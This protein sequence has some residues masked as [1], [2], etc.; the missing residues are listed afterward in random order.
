MHKDSI[1]IRL[2]LPGLSDDAETAVVL[3]VKEWQDSIEVVARYSNGEAICPRCGHSTWQVHQWRQQRKRDAKVWGKAMWLLLWK[4]RFRCRVCR[5]VFTEPDPACGRYRR[6][7]RRLR[8]EVAQQ[9][10]EASV[11][12]V[13]P[14]TAAVARWQEVSEGL[15]QRSWRENHPPP[16]RYGA[17]R[18]LGVDGFCVARPRRMWTGLWDLE[19]GKPLTAVAG[20]GQG[21]LRAALEALAR[22]GAVQALSMDLHEPY[23]QSDD[24]EAAAVHLVLPWAAIVADK[25][26]IVALANAASASSDRAL[27]EVRQGRRQRGNL[28]WLLDRGVERLKADDKQRL[29]EELARQCRLRHHRPELAKAWALKEGLRSLYGSASKGEAAVGLDAW[30]EAARDAVDGT[31]LPA[32]GGHSY[33]MA[34]GGAQ[35]SVMPKTALALP[36]YQRLGG[37]SE[38]PTLAAKA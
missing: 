35:L 19:E 11:R 6:T 32:A 25:F 3:G 27:R 31:A 10:R 33:Q 5:K 24:A 20:E 26:H 2:R 16:A 1:T 38:M 36:H 14:R 13:M 15:V 23:R 22:P 7:T 29:V 4:R 30:L 34:R 18:Y 17:P 9:A 28:P 37:G 21:D 12:S 8:R